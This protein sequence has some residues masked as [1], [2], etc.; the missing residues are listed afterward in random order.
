[1]EDDRILEL[2]V[3]FETVHDGLEVL[4]VGCILHRDKFS[5]CANV[6]PEVS[7]L[8]DN[9]QDIFGIFRLGELWQG[10]LDDVVSGTQSSEVGADD[11][12]VT[13][14]RHDSEAFGDMLKCRA[15]RSIIQSRY[16]FLGRDGKD[17]VM[18][19]PTRL[20]Q[21]RAESLLYIALLDSTER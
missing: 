12:D 20:A 15:R 21:E 5:R 13:R 18:Y 3:L 11:N 14:F 4:V 16:V 10:V 17:A 6:P 1:M 7:R 9:V 2:R 19:S 8:V